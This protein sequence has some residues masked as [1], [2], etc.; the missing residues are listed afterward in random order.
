MDNLYNVIRINY[1]FIIVHV[2]SHYLIGKL[3]DDPMNKK[4][5]FKTTHLQ[6]N[7]SSI[8]SFLTNGLLDMPMEITCHSKSVK[9]HKYCFLHVLV[10]ITNLLH[11]K[12]F[13]FILGEEVLVFS[14]YDVLVFS[15]D[16][17]CVIIWTFPFVLLSHIHMDLSFLRI[18]IGLFLLMILYI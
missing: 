1:V 12:Q 15:F 16:V 8:K 3:H 9:L 13:M 10:G 5:Q 17:I 14:Q 6:S 2:I 4:A 18:C 11:R 7:S